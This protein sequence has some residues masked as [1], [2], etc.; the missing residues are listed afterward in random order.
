MAQNMTCHLDTLLARTGTEPDS[1]TG[2]LAPPIHTASTYVRNSDGQPGPFVYS[3]LGNPT[4]LRFEEALASAEG[5][6]RAMGF[7]SGMTAAMTICQA[8]DPGDHI[9][10]PHDI[11]FGVRTLIMD[12]FVRWGLE[13]SEVDQRDQAAVEEAIQHNTRLVWVETP[14]NPQLNIIDIQAMADVA[15]N[16]GARLIVDNTWSTP[17]ITRPIDHGADVVLHSVTKYLGGHSDVLGGALVFAREDDLCERV[18]SLSDEG[19][20]VLDPFGSW[21][22]M[23]GMRSLG[24]RLRQ[25]SATAMHIATWLEAHDSVEAVHYPGLPSHPGHAI[26]T[27]QMA[28]FGGMLSFRVNGGPTMALEVVRRS[29]LFANATSLGGTESLMEHRASIE[30]EDSPTPRNLLRMSV[31]L[32]HAED[33]LADLHAAL[34]T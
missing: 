20:A 1:E 21:L 4:R 33:L 5:G 19:G 32:E 6:A 14:S 18:S 16:A 23:R 26:A 13:V 17:L 31:G 29:R 30:G 34:T 24:P 11:Y 8:L 3:R 28:L 15:H 27:R 9:I 22:V 7:S 12:H 10:L 2:A 25:Q